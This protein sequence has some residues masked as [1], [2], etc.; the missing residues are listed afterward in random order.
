MAKEKIIKFRVEPELYEV[1]RKFG[2]EKGFRNISELMRQLIIMHFM[3][4]LLGYFKNKTVSQ[5][6][7]EFFQKYT[8]L[9]DT[10]TPEKCI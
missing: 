4:I 5:I 3:G 10:G 1:I 7:S 2:E 6:E 8:L 9:N